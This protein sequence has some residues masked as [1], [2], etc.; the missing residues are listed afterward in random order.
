MR[1]S[2]YDPRRYPRSGTL[3][4]KIIG[5][6]RSHLKRVP[7]RLV[8]VRISQ[9]MNWLGPPTEGAAPQ[10]APSMGKSGPGV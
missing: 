1:S 5:Q 4:K 10:R 2:K 9:S 6:Q 7:P 8:I 3:N